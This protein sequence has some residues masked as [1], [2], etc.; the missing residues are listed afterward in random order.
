MLTVC[1]GVIQGNVVIHPRLY[2]LGQRQL[3]LSLLRAYG[4]PAAALHFY[5]RR[6][7]PPFMSSALIEREHVERVT[8]SS[9]GPISCQRLS[10]WTV[11]IVLAYNS[12][13]LQSGLESN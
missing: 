9:S 2:A 12:K 4:F 3:Q 8:N 6:V 10:H 5:G 13:A 1:P 7:S 11:T